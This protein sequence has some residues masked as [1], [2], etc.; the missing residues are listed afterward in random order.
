[1]RGGRRPRGLVRGRKPERL[2]ERPRQSLEVERI[3]Q[4][5]R[6]GRNELGR[7]AQTSRNNGLRRRQRL[8]DRLAEWLEQRGGTDDIG[9]A[10]VRGDI[11][12]RGPGP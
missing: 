1:M 9:A 3:H 10:D 4:D 8:E 11:S 5:T 7:P 6:L 2:L 12:M